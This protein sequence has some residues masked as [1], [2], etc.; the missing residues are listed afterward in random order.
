MA[1]HPDRIEEQ[2]LKLKVEKWAYSHPKPTNIAHHE[3]FRF[4]SPLDILKEVR[5]CSEFGESYIAGRLGLAKRHGLSAAERLEE[6]IRNN[7]TQ[8]QSFRMLRILAWELRTLPEEVVLGFKQNF[9][10]S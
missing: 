5:I 2:K 9:R 6:D 4:Y 1:V 8:P 7:H 3:N 10:R